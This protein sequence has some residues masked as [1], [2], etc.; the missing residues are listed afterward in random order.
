MSDIC[1][2]RILVKGVPSQLALKLIATRTVLAHFPCPL[3]SPPP[4]FCSTSSSKL[5]VLRRQQRFRGR[6][7]SQNSAPDLSAV[8]NIAT[9]GSSS[10]NSASGG[11]AGS[12]G[13]SVNGAGVSVGGVGGANVNGAGVSVGGVGGANVNGAGVSVGGVGGAGVGGAS[14]V[15][16]RQPMAQGLGARGRLERRKSSVFS[17]DSAKRKWRLLERKV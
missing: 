5:A 3:L 9:A 4:S 8:A 14:G 6:L 10:T 11:S 12:N 17:S 16:L 7:Q 1:S 2:Q 13:G 15:V